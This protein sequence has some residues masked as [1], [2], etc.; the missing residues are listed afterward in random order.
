M[1]RQVSVQGE[2]DTVREC[3]GA[4]NYYEYNEADSADGSL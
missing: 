4:Q 1:S 3:E 2:I